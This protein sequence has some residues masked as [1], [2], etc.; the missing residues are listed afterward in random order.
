MSIY[1]LK[2]VNLLES[3]YYFFFETEIFLQ[4]LWKEINYIQIHSVQN[5]GNKNLK[6][7]GLMQNLEL[8]RDT[9]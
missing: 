4:K 7:I 2:M 8:R 9:V 5:Y 6:S 1:K 3:F